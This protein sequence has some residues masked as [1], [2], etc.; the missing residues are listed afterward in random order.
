[1]DLS[2]IFQERFILISVFIIIVLASTF[3]MIATWKNRTYM[4]K[5]LLIVVFVISA[6]IIVGALFALI[7]SISFGYNS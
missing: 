2:I 5:G 1:M 4:P 6:I 7:F 3:L